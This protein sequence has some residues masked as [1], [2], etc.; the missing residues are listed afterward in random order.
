MS[1]AAGP[2][3]GIDPDRIKLV[4]PFRDRG[5]LTWYVSYTVESRRS[6]RVST[7]TTDR[8]SAEDFRAQLV[9][10]LVAGAAGDAA[11]G[12][13]L[14]VGRLLDDYIKSREGKIKAH[15]RLG[16]AVAR[17]RPHFGPLT[18]PMLSEGIYDAYVASR[19]RAGIK[20]GTI[21][22]ELVV[23]RTALN[24]AVN[25]RIIEAYPPIEMPR[26]PASKNR[27]M[28]HDEFDA[29]LDA[30]ASQHMRVYLH[31]AI[32]TAARKGAILELTWDRVDF[33]RG[34]ID[35]RVSEDDDGR[36]V[37]ETK[38]RRARI[39]MTPTLRQVLM[40]ARE[41]ATTDYVVEYRGGPVVDVKKGFRE[42][43]VR[44][45]FTYTVLDKD[46]NPVVSKY[47][48][49]LVRHKFSPHDLRHTAASWMIQ[50]GVAEEEVAR[51]LG[52]TV[53]MVRRVYGHH[54]PEFLARAAAAVD[55]GARRRA[56][57]PKEV[58]EA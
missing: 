29:L 54:S 53:Q 50:S 51:Y 25:L 26:T 37:E 43:C 31:L 45:G 13:E 39:P 46:G 47:G 24:R 5:N 57:K 10:G 28:T 55:V 6:Q 41:A 35:L 44:A 4:Q 33:E 21:R 16:F 30:A 17:L 7:R 15:E 19:R 34:L 9:A 3:R 58:E 20:N 52:D 36:Q 49:P 56:K 1:D 38:K 12:V 42:A 40:D 2:R 14:T 23:L 32:A 48:N 11:H 27:W 8:R 18:I 22:K